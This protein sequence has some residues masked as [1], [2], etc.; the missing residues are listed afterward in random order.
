MKLAYLVS[1]P[2]KLTNYVTST[3]LSQ[4]AYH[5]GTQG[6]PGKLIFDGISWLLKTI[7]KSVTQLT[8]WSFKVIESDAA[9]ALFN[10][11]GEVWNSIENTFVFMLDQS[12]NITLSYYD[13]LACY[14]NKYSSMGVAQSIF[15]AIKAEGFHVKSHPV[16]V[17]SGA[18][19]MYYAQAP[20][21]RSTFNDTF[22][23]LH[24]LNH[25]SG[26]D[27]YK[28]LGWHGVAFLSTTAMITLN[29]VTLLTPICNINKAMVAGLSVAHALSLKYFR[30]RKNDSGIYA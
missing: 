9:T 13:K 4:I 22:N 3:L 1:V 28:N 16:S 21:L 25:N 18:S 26:Y 2:E 17:L 15:S 11:I 7:S 10:S 14:C 27:E 20:L 24:Q 23:A 19:V 29:M 30:E 5:R 8:N 6:L 12:K